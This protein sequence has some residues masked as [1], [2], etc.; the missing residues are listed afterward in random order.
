[1]RETPRGPYWIKIL[2]VLGLVLCGCAGTIA[3][4][5]GGGEDREGGA[6]TA[7]AIHVNQHGYLPDSQKMAVVQTH[8]SRPL[9]WTMRDENATP[10]AAGQTR[11]HGFD[12][13]SG[14][15]LH[16]LDF[17]GTPTHEG[18]YT[19]TAGGVTSAAFAI[20]AHLFEPL[21]QDALNYFYQ[22]RIGT[23]I[24]LEY[25][26]RPDL[27]RP[28]ALAGLTATCF[29]G[30]DKTGRE[31]PGCDYELDV[32]GGWFDAGDFGVY[33][34]NMAQAIWQLQNANE[35]LVRWG[36]LAQSGWSD[37]DIHAPE[38]GNGVSQLL[39][40][41]R[42]GME[43]MM[44]LQ[45]PDGARAPVTQV[46]QSANETSD[47][48]STH[49]A[50]IDVSG[51][52]HHKLAGRAWPPFPIR[53]EKAEQERLLYPPSTAASLALAAVGAQCAR[54]WKGHDDAFASACLQAALRAYAAATRL[55]NAYAWNNFDGSGPYGDTD[56]SDE[57]AW[58]ATELFITTRDEH[59]LEDAKAFGA[60]TGQP[61][62]YYWADVTLLPAL[63]L[64]TVQP[65]MDEAVFDAALGQI[66]TGAQALIAIRNE[67]GFAVPMAAD[68]YNWGSNGSLL[69]AATLLAVAHDI[70]GE[71]IYFAAVIDAMDYVLGRNVLSQSYITGYGVRPPQN[72]HH[73]LWAGGF[74]EGYPLPPPGVL[75]GGPNDIMPADG[76]AAELAKVCAPMACWLD[77]EHAYSLN[78]VAIN[79][80]AALVWVAVYLDTKAGTP[81]H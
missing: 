24:A 32:A 69:N 73:R 54:N 37:D 8:A 38:Q 41:A 20:D 3:G 80:N 39:D 55:P 28:P 75:S 77:N 67:Q 63:S 53:P 50:V 18:T 65:P 68:A 71:E 36:R 13:A 78:E 17:T 5:E 51:M 60:F 62:G 59:F 57:F 16:Q 43:M 29:T 70:S 12:A 27:A 6:A 33:P 23:P 44:R 49:I 42:W 19:I 10:V 46:A 1:M 79:W 34:V 56:L 76:V 15:H 48:A 47:Y 26:Q 61:K 31:W 25:V 58:A 30:Q 35:R 72:I 64:A 7:A 74:A 40:E 4:E 66:M 9:D 22:S 2:W 52:V 14:T 45:A 11:P 21:A 81:P